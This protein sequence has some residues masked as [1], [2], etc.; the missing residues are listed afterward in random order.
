MVIIGVKSLETICK[1]T[2]VSNHVYLTDSILF[3][4]HIGNRLIGMRATYVDESYIG[5]ILNI[6]NL[7][8]LTE[9][10]FQ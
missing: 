1:M 6:V 7:K 3:F 8:K 10:K 4:K 2:S 5:E 9:D